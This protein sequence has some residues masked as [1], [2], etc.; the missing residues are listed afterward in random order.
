MSTPSLPFLE[1]CRRT[2]KRHAMLSPGDRVLVAVSGGPDSLALL[3]ALWLLRDE[4]SLSLRVAHLDHQTRP[5][6]GQ[7][8][9]FVQSIAQ[10]LGLPCATRT[11]DVPAY[12]RARR[13]PLQVAAREVRYRFFEEEAAAHGYDRIALGH[14]ADDQAET[15]LMRL[16]RGAG[17]RGLAGIP[18]VRDPYVRPLIEITRREIEQ[19][20]ADQGVAALQDPSNLKPLYLRNRIRLE[21]L[22]GL[23]PY[24]PNLPQAL[25]RLAD[26]LRQED[27]YLEEHCRGLL[28]DLLL[29][30][31]PGRLVLDRKRLEGL[32]LALQRRI[33]REGIQQ[34]KG[35]LRS[36]S[37]RH[38]EE[39]LAGLAGR[40][41]GKRYCLPGLWVEKGPQSL[42]LLQAD[43]GGKVEDEARVEEELPVPGCRGVPA[44]SLRLD[45]SLV[46]RE[47]MDLQLPHGDPWLALLDYGRIQLPLRLRTRWPG[48]RFHPLGAGGR[49]KLKD[50]LIDEKIP[51][52]QRD[53]I[54]LLVSGDGEILWVVGVRISDRA[55]VTQ[56]THRFLR[57]K[58]SPFNSPE[59]SSY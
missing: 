51:R 25:T 27:R 19:F 33:L 21:L 20:L 39:V 13:L 52:D 38:L 12:R 43:P 6:T 3:R 37:Q 31:G 10:E 55:K 16:L 26:I 11:V 47:E 9:R 56:A 2:L 44:L 5:E 32:P 28:S 59:R 8:T 18:P 22:P 4:Y 49:K 54:P 58:V 7:E 36:I 46:E 29:E 30:S 24:N 42:I 53:R 35:D 1:K 34:L 17:P 14:T 40:E 57:V 48:D 15:V 45:L 41:A 50:F 23:R